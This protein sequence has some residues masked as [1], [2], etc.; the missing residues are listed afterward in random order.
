LI[1]QDSEKVYML[2]GSGKKL[3]ESLKKMDGEN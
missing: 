3:M 1:E 2:S